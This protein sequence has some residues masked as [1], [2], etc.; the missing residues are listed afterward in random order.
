MKLRLLSWKIEDK[1]NL[2]EGVFLK[3]LNVFLSSALLHRVIQEK[4]GIKWKQ[5]NSV[6]TLRMIQ[7]WK[8]GIL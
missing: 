4:N 2:G 3:K 6:K 7:Y 1:H 8:Q 5:E